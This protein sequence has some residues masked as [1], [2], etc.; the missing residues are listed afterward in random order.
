MADVVM[1]IQGGIDKYYI[2][3]RY[4]RMMII[5]SDLDGNISNVYWKNIQDYNHYH[6]DFIVV[7]TEKSKKRRVLISNAF[8]DLQVTV[9]D[10]P[11]K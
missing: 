1:D 4:P 8:P 9:F 10:L 3:V 2:F 7:D 11:N 5:E 6:N